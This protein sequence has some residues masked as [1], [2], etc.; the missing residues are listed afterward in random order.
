ML[1]MTHIA[2]CFVRAYR[3]HRLLFTPCLTTLGLQAV[4]QSSFT[5]TQGSIR[6]FSVILCI[7]EMPRDGMRC[8]SSSSAKGQLSPYMSLSQSW[9]GVSFQCGGVVFWNVGRFFKHMTS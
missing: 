6:G 1:I 9:L 2:C 5:S 7:I 3:L 8:E 4:S